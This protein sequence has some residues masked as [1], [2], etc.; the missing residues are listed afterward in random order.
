MN[1]QPARDFLRLREYETIRAQID[2]ETARALNSVSRGR[3]QISFD[4]EPGFHQITATSYVGTVVAGNLDVLVRPK[5]GLENLFALL[6]V[7]F[8]D[9]SWYKTDFSF[10]TSTSLLPA[11]A[12]HFARRLEM[13]LA[14]GVLRSYRSNEDRLWTVRGRID[15]AETLRRPGL[16]VPIPVRFEEFTADNNENRYLRSAIRRLMRTP[17]VAPAVRTQLHRQL[18]SLEEVSDE[19]V[20]IDLPNQ[21]FFSRLNEYY[22]P[23]LKIAEVILRNLSFIDERGGV[24]ASAFLL[25]MNDL[26]QRFVTERLRAGLRGRLEIVD[27]PGYRLGITNEVEMKPDLVF[28]VGGTDVYVADVKYKLLGRGLGRSHDYYQLLA[29]LTGMDLDEGLL[30]YCQAEGVVPPRMFKVKNSNKILYTYPINLQGSP[31]EL[32]SSLSESGDWIASRALKTAVLTA[33]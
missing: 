33:Q 1:Q 30:I 23:A 15:I 8:P 7:G 28:R 32:F 20:D 10:A 2:P 29:Y 22:R 27:E 21:I 9:E 16:D 11:V 24:K 14:Q 19:L 26:F 5:V 3:L 4:P 13:T 17:G 31:T 18:G 12:A 25:D 6:E